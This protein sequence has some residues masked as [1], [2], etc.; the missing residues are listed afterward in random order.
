MHADRPWGYF[1]SDEAEN[2]E[3]IPGGSANVNGAA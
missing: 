2:I 3:R 1:P